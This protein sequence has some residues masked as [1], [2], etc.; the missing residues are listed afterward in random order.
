[1]D[2]L[3]KFIEVAKG[4]LSVEVGE[5][6]YDGLVEVMGHLLALKS[7]QTATDYMFEPLKETV[8]L[9]QSYDQA[10]TDEIHQQ[11]EVMHGETTVTSPTLISILYYFYI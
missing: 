6:N 1:M 7:R 2:D 4:G 8:E 5:D 9:L 10:I 3:Q 11:L